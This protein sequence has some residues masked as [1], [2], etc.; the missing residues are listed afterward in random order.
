M[1]HDPSKLNLGRPAP[2]EAEVQRL[3]RAAQTAFAAHDHHAVNDA[4]YQAHALARHGN[5]HRLAAEL[6]QAL[7][8]LATGGKPKLLKS[9]PPAKP[10]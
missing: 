10:K 7:T 2:A 9:N 3:L 8:I 4:L 1:P 6:R 5:F